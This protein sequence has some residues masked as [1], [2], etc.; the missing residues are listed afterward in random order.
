[1][2]KETIQAK[3]IK[4]I[5]LGANVIQ[6]AGTS[7]PFA[8]GATFHPEDDIR[9]IGYSFNVHHFD[10]IGFDSGWTYGSAFI[11]KHGDPTALQGRFGEIFSAITCR[12]CLV[13][14]ASTQC[15]MVD[16]KQAG[17]TIFYPEGYGIDVDEGDSVMLNVYVSNTMAND[18]RWNFAVTLHYVE[19]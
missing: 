2:S 16:N 3:K 18:H 7:G 17:E 14:V 4:S 9:I 15:T 5:D 8:V 13:G 19:R 1:M 11:A 6:P 12:E 10:T